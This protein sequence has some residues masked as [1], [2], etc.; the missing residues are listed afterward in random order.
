MSKRRPVRVYFLDDDPAALWLRG[1]TGDDLGPEAPG[2]S[3]HLLRLDHF[4]DS[5]VSIEAP[6]ERGLI[7]RLDEHLEETAQ[8]E[9]TAARELGF[10]PDPADRCARCSHVYAQHNPGGGSCGACGCRSY[11]GEEPEDE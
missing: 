1:Q 7:A 6:Y 8:L 3:I 10:G 2:S 11:L 4:D 9:E 5:L